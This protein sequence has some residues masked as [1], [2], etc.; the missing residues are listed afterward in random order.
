MF[1]KSQSKTVNI[2]TCTMIWT[3][4][5]LVRFACSSFELA[6]DDLPTI[7]DSRIDRKIAAD[8]RQVATPWLQG[9][10]QR[11]VG[12]GTQKRLHHP[13]WSTP[14]AFV[15]IRNMKGRESAAPLVNI[16]WPESQATVPA[17]TLMRSKYPDVHAP[18]KKK[19]QNWMFEFH[20]KHDYFADKLVAGS[21]ESVLS[22]FLPISS[23]DRK[24]AFGVSSRFL[25][26]KNIQSS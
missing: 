19:T 7:M 16:Y 22:R 13:E 18:P 9:S 12:A 3:L 5:L 25:P 1:S 26:M 23:P 8:K 17:G 14:G 21:E 2:N 20:P 11:F 4:L 24:P 15:K 6:P 10:P